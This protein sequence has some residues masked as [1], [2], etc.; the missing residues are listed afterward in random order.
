MKRVYLL[1]WSPRLLQS[2]KQAIVS[3][4][5]NSRVSPPRPQPQVKKHM[6]TTL[7]L[8]AHIWAQQANRNSSVNTCTHAQNKCKIQKNPLIIRITSLKTISSLTSLYS[9]QRANSKARL[10]EQG[11]EELQGNTYHSVQDGWQKPPSTTLFLQCLWPRLQQDLLGCSAVFHLDVASERWL[12]QM[13]PFFKGVA[14]LKWTHRNLHACLRA[15]DC[16]C[17]LSATLPPR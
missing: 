14:S 17:S 15:P 2:T 10:D 4:H 13:D 12:F 6:T 7:V 1:H 9:S 3:G 5:M 16:A 8:F 11:G